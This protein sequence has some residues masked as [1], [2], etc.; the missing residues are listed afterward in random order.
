MDEDGEWTL[1]LPGIAIVNALDQGDNLFFHCRATGA[2]AVCP[3]CA[4]PSTTV[5][6][7]RTRTLKD[8]PVFTQPVILEVRIRRF[9]CLNP[10]CP[11]TT[12]TETL[13]ELAGAC[14]RRTRR[15][16]Q[17]LRQIAIELGGEPGRRLSRQ[18]AMAVSG[19]TLIRML[20]QEIVPAVSASEI[21]VDDWALRK[22]HT[23]GTIIVDHQSHRPIDL[24]PERTAD[25]V[26]HW[27][28]AHPGVTLVTRDRSPEYARG[29]REGAPAAQQIADRWHLLSNVRE[30]VERLCQRLRTDLQTLP[31]VV[32]G[33][34]PAKITV[35]DRSTRRCATDDALRQARRAKRQR[36]YEKVKALQGQGFNIQQV[37]RALKMSWVMARHF[38]RCERYP[39][40]RSSARRASVLDPYAS[41]LQSRWDT[42]CHNAQQL[43]RDIRK[44][45]FRGS[46][47]MVTL[48]AQL[49]RP[50]SEPRHGPTSTAQPQSTVS[51]SSTDL[52]SPRRLAWLLLKSETALSDVEKQILQHIQNDQRIATS[53][54]LIRRFQT[55]VNKRADTELE[56][57][58]ADCDASGIPELKSFSSGLRSDL[59]AVQAALKTKLN[60]GLAEGH[61]NRLKCI[62][63]Q[64]YGRANLDL[65]RIRCLCRA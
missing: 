52:P 28:K 43:W 58:L 51:S 27:L 13:P 1:H 30:A 38:M 63:R 12:F 11:R 45:G 33:Q 61:I 26:A 9:R 59:A 20:R 65:L 48:W 18:L 54:L 36:R 47:R 50:A 24:L 62:K 14:A 15:L 31:I 19:D 25:T 40:T 29:I 5:H 22:G 56:A 35:F 57:W 21:G 46:S 42:G 41:Y 4:T 49:R 37:A 32:T 23:Y 60:N 16:R 6:S 44:Q 8:L 53:Q 2:T 64:M 3:Q 7:Y 55:L 39:E 17:A 10:E 34:L